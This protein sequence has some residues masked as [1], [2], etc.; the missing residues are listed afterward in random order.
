MSAAGAMKHTPG[1]HEAAAPGAEVDGRPGAVGSGDEVGGPDQVDEPPVGDPAAT[2]YDLVVRHG[3]VCRGSAEGGRAEAQE[4]AG[5]L[6][7]SPPGVFQA[8]PGG[9]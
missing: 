1:D 7:E 8:G 4:Q 2:A 5:Q 9:R 6:T 3:D